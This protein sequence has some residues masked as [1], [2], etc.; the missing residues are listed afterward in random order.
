MGS[1]PSAVE[2]VEYER[3]ASEDIIATSAA[4]QGYRVDME[5]HHTICLRLPHHQDH[6]FIGLYDGHSGSAASKFLS[7]QF[8]REIDCL[9]KITKTNLDDIVRRMDQ[10]W[11]KDPRSS[12]GSTVLFAVV[13][14]PKGNSK[15][16]KVMVG[17]AGD[18]R[19][20]A[21]KDGDL[22]DM[23]IDHKPSNP[24]EQARIEHANGWVNN[25]RVDGEL[26]V[27]RSFG[28]WNMKDDNNGTLKYHELKV[29]AVLEFLEIELSPGD[30]LLLSCD[31]LTEQLENKDIFDKLKELKKEYPDDADVVLNGLMQRALTSGSKDNMSTILVEFRAGDY[32][33]KRDRTRM[34][35]CRP[36]PLVWNLNKSRFF[37]AYMKN[38][39]AMGLKD[40]KELRRAA[41]HRDEVRAHEEYNGKR[42]KETQGVQ[43]ETLLVS[44][45]SGDKKPLSTESKDDETDY[46]KRTRFNNTLEKIK[47]YLGQLEKMNFAN[48][49]E[50]KKTNYS[51]FKDTELLLIPDHENYMAFKTEKTNAE[52]DEKNALSLDENVPR[53]RFSSA[54]DCDEGTFS[55]GETVRVIVQKSILVK[56][57][58]KLSIVVNEK[59]LQCMGKQGRVVTAEGKK[60]NVR[61]ENIGEIYFPVSVLRPLVVLPKNVKQ[62]LGLVCKQINEEPNLSKSPRKNLNWSL[63]LEHIRELIGIMYPKMNN[64]Q[65]GELAVRWEGTHGITQAGLY[66]AFD[67]IQTKDKEELITITKRLE[68]F[69]TTELCKVQIGM[70]NDVNVVHVPFKNTTLLDVAQRVSERMECDV[71]SVYVMYQRKRYTSEQ[72]LKD[73]QLAKVVEPLPNKK[74]KVFAGMTKIKKGNNEDLKL[75]DRD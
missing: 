29:T 41:Y 9:D 5:D 6:A 66:Q 68:E 13:E 19:A 31:G 44:L 57:C 8:W 17:W 61:F 55:I 62:T 39:E 64:K 71:S 45:V 22:K 38:I 12:E 37:E 75:D 54:W 11:S 14:R 40:C 15:S 43:L 20:I 49:E 21:V 50:P 28:D 34:R 16:Y 33:Y 73:L 36:G 51:A 42:P 4:M 67:E 30:L 26:A 46:Q 52:S 35:T 25:D 65:V 70:V 58:G 60:A 74:T 53:I 24:A 47:E 27:S 1:L 3:H 63:K 59:S 56:E 18:S 72:P 10:H 2:N 7:Q 32:F 48:V 23:S 69:L